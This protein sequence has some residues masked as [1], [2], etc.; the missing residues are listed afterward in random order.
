MKAIAGIWQR[1]ATAAAFLVPGLALTV[2]SGY[3]WG[4]LLLLLCSL[5]SA[6]LWLR[7]RPRLTW[8]LAALVAMVLY[9]GAVWALDWQ[10]G[11]SWH[12]LDRAAKYALALP[13]L[14]Y[15]WHYPPKA[16]ALWWGMGAGAAGSGVLALYQVGV[17]GM[18]R[19]AGFTNAIQYGNLSLVL[20]VM[21]ALVLC[22]Q[23]R[24]WQR[25]QALGM[26]LAMLLGLAGSL[27]SLSRGGWLALALST[28]LWLALL[29][30]WGHRQMLLRVATWCLA[31]A[32]L[33]AVFQGPALWQRWTVARA[34][35][36]SYARAGD[37]QTSVGQRLDHWKLA[38][39]MGCDRPWLGW[40]RVG[41]NA[42]KQRRVAAG[43]AHPM[44][45]QFDHSHNE[46]IDLFVKR[47][48]LGVLA[49]LVFYA[50]PCWLFWPTA[51]RLAAAPGLSQGTALAL[52][53]VGLS[54]PVLYLGFGLTQAF[55]AH[56]SGNMFYLFMVMLVF[57]ARYAPASSCGQS[58][59]LP[60]ANR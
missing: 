31:G 50:V 33:A 57:A 5:C 38:W 52:H 35:V 56:N 22:T 14:F 24:H 18:E 23:G 60:L 8:S 45:L 17:L 59:L 58:T 9:M 47:G 51:A 11:A 2:P 6:G 4:A 10:I 12:H 3:S 28:P 1:C 16:V 36:Q 49:L 39:A 55:L 13:C 25:W 42:E 53:L 34:E 27:L 26:G 15:L 20:G 29:W 19:A 40:G 30:R 37:A 54:L 7:Q 48:L 43:Q 46:V 44:V 21:C 41:Y 32:A